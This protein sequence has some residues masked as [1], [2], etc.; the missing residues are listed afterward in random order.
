M[1]ETDSFIN[2]VTE[3]VRRDRLFALFRRYAWVA[4]LAV[5]LIVGGTWYVDN[6][7]NRLQAAAEAQGD[8]ILTALETTE[9]AERADALSAIGGDAGPGVISALLA[10][11]AY[12][13]AG[14]PG[15]AAETLTTLAASADTPEVYRQL[16]GFKALTLQAGILS[17]EER[18]RGFEAFAAGGGAFRP[19]AEEQIALIE[20]GMGDTEAA[21]SRL[22][23]LVEDA[24][25]S[26]GL[27]DRAQ[28]LI[29]A[30]GGDL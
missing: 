13:E 4:V 25:A 23:T 18:K 9:G 10:A 8:A 22:G 16:A 12:E 11:A 19:L 1:S 17:P 24:A 21:L 7:S 3:E 29:V 26:Q 27:R 30:L 28:S 14:D 15:A 2:E 20:I 6:R 5:L